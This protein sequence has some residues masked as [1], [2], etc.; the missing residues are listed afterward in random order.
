MMQHNTTLHWSLECIPLY[1]SLRGYHKRGA[2]KVLAAALCVLFASCCHPL[3]KIEVYLL[4][5]RGILQSNIGAQQQEVYRHSA[6]QY[7]HIGGL[8]VPLSSMRA[9]VNV[10]KYA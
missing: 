8:T 7:P 5:L 3:A 4:V 10:S 1:M 6:I 2:S 9:M